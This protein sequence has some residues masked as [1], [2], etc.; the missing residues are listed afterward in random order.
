MIKIYQN[1]IGLYRY[2]ADILKALS[3]PI[4]LA[5]V[6]FLEHDEKC[7][8]EIVEFLGEKQ[9]NVSRHLAILRNAGIVETRKDGS[10]VFYNLRTPCVNVFFNCIDKIIT[11]RHGKEK[12][13]IKNI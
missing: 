6:E 4:R 7:V 11:K 10:M 12:E 5:I 13:V 2:R 1:N 8:C 3:H 9:S